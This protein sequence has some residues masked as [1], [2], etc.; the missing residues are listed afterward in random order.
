MA[1]TTGSTFTSTISETVTLN[2]AVRGNT[3]TISIDNVNNIGEKIVSVPYGEQETV[4]ATFASA[5]NTAPYP[6]YDYQ[7]AKYVR[8][9]NLSETETIEI[10]WVSNGTDNQCNPGKSADSCRFKLGPLQTS[11]MFD[12]SR[13][14]RGEV[15]VPNWGIGLTDLN[16]VTIQ[17]R[18]EA[19]E[20][21]IEL[22][23]A[24]A[25]PVG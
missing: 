20:V 9:T 14:K 1:V 15:T 10:A 23:V 16:Y 18:S 4:I 12:T 2:G 8:V 25:P 21:D 22:F 11:I 13:G 19:Q 24:S 3:N 5:V 7:N 6:N 17:N